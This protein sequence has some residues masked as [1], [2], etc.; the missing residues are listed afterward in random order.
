MHPKVS[1]IMSG[2][3]YMRQ[4]RFESKGDIEQGHCHVFDH[5]TL[6]ATG[7]LKVRAQGK[8]TVFVAPSAIKILANEIHE[9]EAI[10]DNTL[11]YCVHALRDAVTEDV[12]PD[13]MQHTDKSINAVIKDDTMLYVKPYAKESVVDGCPVDLAPIAKIDST[14]ITKE[15]FNRNFDTEKTLLVKTSN[16][17]QDGPSFV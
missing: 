11:A 7:S 5:I 13:T 14:K 6:L 17:Q 9:L 1:L 3:L 12:L 4:M 2:N 10:E 15:T 16:G 8:E